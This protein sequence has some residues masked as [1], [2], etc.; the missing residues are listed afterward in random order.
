MPGKP[1]TETTDQ[2]CTECGAVLTPATGPTPTEPT[3]PDTTIT[4]TE[5][6][7]TQPNPGTNDPTAPVTDPVE[8]ETSDFAIVVI[9]IIGAA[10]G[11]GILLIVMGRKK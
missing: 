10:I 1:A 5:P 8:D 3:Q 11:A 9:L 2:V 7:V 6:K 4:P